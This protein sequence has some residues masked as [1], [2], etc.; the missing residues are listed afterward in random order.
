[1][2]G[3]SY[4]L[5]IRLL[6]IPLYVDLSFL[7]VLPLLAWIIGSQ[8]GYFAKMFSIP[9]SPA[10]TSGAMP[11]VLGLV[12]AAGLFVSVVIHE[13]GHAVTARVWGQRAAD[14]ALVSGRG[15]AI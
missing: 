2:F 12:A 13:L 15:G 8:V 7:I 9:M 14:H 3:R 11:Y 1:M 4:R 10:L 5:P 6:G